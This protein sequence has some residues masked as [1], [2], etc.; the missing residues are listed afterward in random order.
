[1]Q[2]SAYF[3]NNSSISCSVV[4]STELLS[5]TTAQIWLCRKPAFAAMTANVCFAAKVWATHL[6]LDLPSLELLCVLE[7][8]LLREEL[9]PGFLY[10]RALGSSVLVALT[11]KRDS[12]LPTALIWS[13]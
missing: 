3:E 13:V 7:H 11:Q 12:N 2:S 5:P 6:Y 9:L 4:V 8:R 10:A 1:M